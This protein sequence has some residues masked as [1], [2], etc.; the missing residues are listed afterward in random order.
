MGAAAKA[1]RRVKIARRI[2][3][4]DDRTLERLERF[5]VRGRL[6]TIN[7]WDARPRSPTC[8]RCW[9]RA[10][11][12]TLT[13]SRPP[14]TLGHASCHPD[15]SGDAEAEARFR[16][17]S[18]AYAVLSKPRSRLL[19]DRLAYRGPGGGG[20][21]PAHEGVGKPTRESAHLSNDE[22]VDWV[23]TDEPVS[24]TAPVPSEERLLRFMA[25]AALIVAI[26]FLVAVLLNAG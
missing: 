15:A 10:A 18:H 6:G 2:R 19:Y 23:F 5:R 4:S 9:A 21:G 13:S 22:L 16:E 7:P 8:T 1:S 25:A 12:P 17:V 26:V 24:A 11:R 14:T 3:S 20:F